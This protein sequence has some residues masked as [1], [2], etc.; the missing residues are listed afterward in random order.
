[1]FGS[2]PFADIAFSALSGEV[3][4]DEGLVNYYFSRFGFISSS[5][6]TPSLTQY[7]PRVIQPLSFQR[8]IIN[9]EYM[10]GIA[11][12]QGE[13]V[14][15]NPDGGLDS[16]LTS[17]SFD[18]RRV[19]VKLG[20]TEFDSTQFGTIFDGKVDSMESNE[21][22]IRFI[23]HDKMLDLHVPMQTGTGKYSGGGGVNGTT[24]LTDKP[25]PLAFGRVLNIS[26]VLVDPVNLIYQV[27]DGSVSDITAVY[28][29]G[30]SLAEVASSVAPGLGEYQNNS[31]VGRF[32][33]GG[34]PDGTVTADV[35]G[36]DDP[37]Y[38]S[39]TSDIIKRIILNRT[40]L[41]TADIVSTMFDELGTLNNNAIG[42]WLG[43]EEW[44]VD[45]VVDSLLKGIGAYA[46][47][48][49]LGQMEVG[50]FD[51]P[52]NPSL[53][54]FTL[55]NIISI[56]RSNVSTIG[57][58]PV[59]MCKVTYQRN[60]TVQNDL[61]GSVPSS[62]VAFA[63]EAVRLASAS[64]ATVKL[65]FARAHEPDPIEAFFS[66]PAA[67]TAEAQ[68]ILEIVQ[69]PH[70]YIEIV[71]KADV[72]SLKLN[73]VVDITYPRWELKNGK[74]GRIVSIQLDAANNEARYTI[75]I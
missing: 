70:F 43:P 1:M 29:R 6:D 30:V 51:L 22:A 40:S 8:S 68:R 69:E 18:G 23:I 19:V 62:R 60:F 44:F 56:T 64:N 49:R 46:S 11:N 27:H 72:Y 25:K 37:S 71:C 14:L 34:A 5:G 52:V 57:Y 16:F 15:T 54:S 42:V 12:S 67:A 45:D 10:S 61:A 65:R 2:N 13:I 33:L 21:D 28:D 17:H 9:G 20:T 41:T 63:T 3:Q 59:W 26:A 32:K 24:N 31:S 75:F 58:P 39:N 74:L 7:E 55:D 4:S 36:D 35:T 66:G 38:I 53:F 48:N 50:R 47:F 73:D